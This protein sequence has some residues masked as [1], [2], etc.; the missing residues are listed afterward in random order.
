MSDMKKMTGRLDECIRRRF[1]PE[2]IQEI[3]AELFWGDTMKV[4]LPEIVSTHL[5]N[6][7]FFEEGLTRFLLK[8]LQPGMSFLDIGAHFGYF[9]LLAST[10][11]G[12]TGCVHA[13]E[14]IPGAFSML[15][16]NTTNRA[17][18]VTNNLAVW[19]SITEIEMKD[20]GLQFSAY[21]SVFAPRLPPDFWERLP[22]HKLTVTAVDIDSY[23]ESTNVR[24]DV[25][26]I[27]AESAEFEVL[28]GMVGVLEEIRPVVILEV[29]D[30][31]IPGVK[32][33][34]E[35]IEWT[36][37]HRYTLFGNMKG[38]IVPVD[39]KTHYTYDNVFLV[40]IEKTVGV[41]AF[42]TVR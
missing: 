23:V 41:Q 11:V 16:K 34:K 17:N 30:E 14:P 29:G 40:P 15:N 24:P 27:D 37:Q 18:I 28:K 8:T 10:I 22:V 36:L 2:P 13:F 33:C 12:D 26:K 38:N 21:N 39:V 1:T 5:Y 42:L 25:I 20:F 6:F 4:C 7:G 35:V 3:N 19:S 31:N 9:S 32:R